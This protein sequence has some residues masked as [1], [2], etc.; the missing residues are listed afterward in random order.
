MGKN[1]AGLKSGGLGGGHCRRVIRC[2]D[3][4]EK[5]GREEDQDAVVGG[6]GELL[7]S[8]DREEHHYLRVSSVFILVVR[9]KTAS[10][11]TCQKKI[12]N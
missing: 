6:T 1:A 5:P 9:D 11:E 3:G 7:A 2:S 4:K 12:M 8:D 10:G